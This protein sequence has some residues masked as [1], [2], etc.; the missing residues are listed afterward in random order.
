MS[1]PIYVVSGLPRSG[2]SLMMRMLDAGGVPA[3]TD[4]IRTAD[5]DNPRGYFE[6]EAVKRT[7][8]DPSWLD[9]APGKAVKVISQLLCELPP[10]RAYK[11]IVMRRKLGEVSAAQKTMLE[12]R[13]S[14]WRSPCSA[15][16][17]P[18]PAATWRTMARARS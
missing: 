15:W 12:G 6:L 3:V 4:R 2:T 14:P 5:D 11:V 17:W 8:Q 16:A 9:D 7:K 18:R 10:D 1:D 13:R